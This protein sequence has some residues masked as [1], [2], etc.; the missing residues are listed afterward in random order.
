MRKR[1]RRSR[2]ISQPCGKDQNRRPHMK[3]IRIH[4]PGGPEVMKLEDVAE[5]TPGAGQAVVTPEAAGVNYIDVSFPPAVTPAPPA[6]R[7][8]NLPDGLSFRD[9]AAAMLQ[10]MTA[11]YLVGST[12]PVKKGETC[13][14]HAAAGGMGLLLCQMAQMRGAAVIGTVSPEEKAA[15]ARAAGGGH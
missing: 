11:H 7:L 3:A 13:L 4:T 1:S 9:G 12:Y 14:V 2:W 15:L 6:D 8:V 10:R 5:P